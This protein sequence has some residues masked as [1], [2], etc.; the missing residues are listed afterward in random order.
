MLMDVYVLDLFQSLLAFH[1]LDIIVLDGLNACLWVRVC[2][3]AF[4]LTPLFKCLFSL[5]HVIWHVSPCQV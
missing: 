4:I 5:N 3:C 2:V 1:F